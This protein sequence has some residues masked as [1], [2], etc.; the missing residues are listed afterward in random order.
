MRA[1]RVSKLI[2][3]TYD[4]SMVICCSHADELPF[5]LAHQMLLEKDLHTAF[6]C[7]SL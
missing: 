3:R 6:V 5:V 2:R 7:Y 4:P 1:H